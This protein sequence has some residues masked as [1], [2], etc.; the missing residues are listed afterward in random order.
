MSN[1]Q[2]V[3][4]KDKKGND[5]S[6]L[7][8]DMNTEI[9]YVRKRVQGRILS[10]SLETRDFN[11]AKSKV[12]LT[13]SDLLKKPIDYKKKHNK[14][15]ADYY[16]KMMAQKVADGLSEE[17]LKRIRTI[18]EYS[19]KPFWE[20]VQPEDITQDTV[21]EFITWHRRKR[22]DVQ[23]VNVFKYLGNIFNVMVQSGELKLS[24]KP[25]LE[26][27]KEE[28]KHH[29]KQKGRYLTDN[30]VL[31]ILDK[32]D[33][34]TKLIVSI[35][36]CTG[37][38]KM[39]IGAIE[40]SRLKLQDGKYIVTLDTDDT[41]TGLA[42]AV[43]LPKF[44]TPLVT[45]QI[46][47]NSKYLFPQLRNL[48]KHLNSQLIDKGW[49]KAKKDAEIVGRVRFHDLRHTAASNMA[50]QNVNPIVAVTILGMS[51]QT[52]QRVY[53]KL[54]TDDLS[55]A[56]EANASRIEGKICQKTP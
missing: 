21:T 15:F 14:I 55:A 12:L 45:E 37:M 51:F 30:E 22:H 26:L 41:K 20:Y 11:T 31:S 4:Y 1:S 35:S 53:L 24:R 13:L 27:P 9:F 54:S 56:S 40:L 43:P 42:R 44:L 7:Y 16:E 49:M 38:R 2:I 39:E 5:Y 10:A 36:Y 28:Q 19:L 50:K 17:T 23:F 3:K 32:C 47:R 18:Y 46:N 29:A 34:V 33:P 6:Y 48:K 8:I 25:K 52:F